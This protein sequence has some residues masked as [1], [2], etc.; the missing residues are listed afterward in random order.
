MV[1]EKSIIYQVISDMM[2]NGNVEIVT[3]TGSGIT[4]TVTF[5]L[6]GNGN[7]VGELLKR[8]SSFTTITAIFSMTA[9]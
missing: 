6:K 4:R 2:A 3:A 9:I 5:T 1:K 7:M 8:K